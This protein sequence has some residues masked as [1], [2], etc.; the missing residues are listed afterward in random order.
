LR[1]KEKDEKLNFV[2]MNVYYSTHMIRQEKDRFILYLSFSCSI[3][4]PDPGYE[5]RDDE[6]CPNPG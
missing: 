6:K 3:R 5:K 2:G 1:N 4:D